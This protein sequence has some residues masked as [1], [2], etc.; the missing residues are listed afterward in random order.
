MD[1]GDPTLK[2]IK[3]LGAGSFGRV[4]LCKYRNNQKVCVK[5]IIVVNPKVEMG[6]ILEEVYIISQLQHPNIIQFI[7]SFMHAGTVNI[8]M[9]YAPNGTL[10]D[11]IHN[12][13]PKGLTHN[14]IMRYFCDALMGLE[15]L[16][17]RHVIHRDLKPANLLVDANHNLKIAD[18]G[19]SLVHASK[20]HNP[21]ALGT[22]YYTPPEVLRGERFDYKS[23]IWSLG[24]ILYEMCM[25]H[26]PF[27][28]AATLDELRYLIRVLTRQKMDCSNIRKLYGCMW[29]QLCER[30]I[31]TNLQMRISLPE[32]IVLEPSLTIYYYNKYFDYK[33]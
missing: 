6:M 9:E 32:I 30:M 28:Q 18:F 3:V 25:G 22:P 19:I 24:C 26:G 4:F 17:V 2:P 21:A 16:H 8:I 14:E 31:V 7:S 27:S 29:A 20:V 1:L 10:Q 5:R 11:L 12:A 23:D 33:Y 13:R 15:Y